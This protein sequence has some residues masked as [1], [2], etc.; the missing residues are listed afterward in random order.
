MSEPSPIPYEKNNFLTNIIE[1]DLKSGKHKSIVTR[2]PPEP[3]GF[4]HIGHATSIYLNFSLAKRYP[5]SRCH[6]RF[7]DTNP[8]KEDL[9]YVEAIKEDVRWLGF[10]WQD[11]LYFASDY[12]PTLFE[13]ALKLI[14]K[15]LAYVCDLSA[16][17][18]I[19]GR[20]T[21]TEPGQNSPYRDR[22]LEENLELFHKMREGHF[23]N[24]SRVLR[25]KIDMASGNLHMRD[26]V[27]YRIKKISHPRLGNQWN[28]YP[29]YDYAHCLSDAIEKVTHSLC[30]LEFQDHRPLYDWI[31]EKVESPHIPRQYEF[32]RLNVNYTVTSKR[33]LKELVDQGYVSGWD[34][35]RMPTI[36]G[37]RNRGFPPRAIC[38]FCD[39]LGVS[40]N[41]SMTDM[42]LLEE[43]VRSELN[44][45]CPRAMAVLDPLK[46]VFTNADD[47][48]EQWFDIPNHPQDESF[49]S[50][51]VPFTKEIFIDRSDFMVQPEAKFFR[52]KPEG[53]VRLRGGYVVK[54]TK[55]HLDNQ[56]GVDFIEATIDY[57]TLGKKPEGRKVKGVIHWVSAPHSLEAKIVHYDRLFAD[58]NPTQREKSGGRFLDALHPESKIEF[59]SAR[60]EPFLGDSKQGKA[61]Q[62]ERMGYFVDR[63]TPEGLQFTKI[64]SLKDTWAKVQKKG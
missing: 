56:G 35:P 24:G 54:C 36:A 57:D 42:S 22:P 14:E 17:E 16:S 13:W 61:Y 25:A 28:I 3:N 52:L 2:F 26:P 19:K 43:C 1:E 23:D 63:S 10:D 49:G 21:P 5:S 44:E 62:F 64:V 4:L 7:D 45:T 12:F 51:K 55:V 33:R 46:V 41:E 20:G 59:P 29:S 15:G 60:L 39:M 37:M 50:R 30:T 34:D 6:L 8:E 48:F 27:L 11:H 9:R 47:D 40:R 32:S 31:V 38:K 53:E 18:L 58:E